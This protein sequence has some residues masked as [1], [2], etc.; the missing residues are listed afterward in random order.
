MSLHS[1]MNKQMN[2]TSWRNKN[3][4]WNAYFILEQPREDKN[5]CGTRDLW[6]SLQSK[7]QNLGADMCCC[8][9][10]WISYYQLVAHKNKQSILLAIKLQF[11]NIQDWKNVN[12]GKLLS[13]LI[14][15]FVF[16]NVALNAPVTTLKWKY[17][18]T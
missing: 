10:M 14:N 17:S 16:N 18:P 15:L 12:V 9:Y 5:I 11:K 8:T 4:H 7:N 1:G 6:A 2:V 3:A 13:C